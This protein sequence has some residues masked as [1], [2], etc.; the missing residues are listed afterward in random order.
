MFANTPMLP[1]A[2]A[3]C[4]NCKT[5][6]SLL[7]TFILGLKIIVTNVLSKESNALAFFSNHHFF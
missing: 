5:E 6:Q 7:L 2:I 3:C 1:V 4:N